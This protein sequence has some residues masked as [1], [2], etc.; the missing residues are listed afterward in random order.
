MSELIT[1]AFI[2]GGIFLFYWLDEGRRTRRSQASSRSMEHYEKANREA[3]ELRDAK[4]QAE[5][6]TARSIEAAKNGQL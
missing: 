6:E 4:I 1:A 5:R 2:L 3:R